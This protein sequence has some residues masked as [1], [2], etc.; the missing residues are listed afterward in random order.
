MSLLV[1]S[2]RC[3]HSI[4]IIEFIQQHPP[5]HSLVKLHNVNQKGVPNSKITRVPTLLTSDGKILIGPDVRAWL[6]SMLPSTFSEYD[7]CGLGMSC[8]DNSELDTNHFS[9]DMY[10]QSLQPTMTRELEHK[11]NRKIE[12]G[13]QEIKD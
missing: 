6:E 8:L 9:L 3:K 7:G 1:F 10:G 11:I 2:D 13:I 12:E 5:L 4:S